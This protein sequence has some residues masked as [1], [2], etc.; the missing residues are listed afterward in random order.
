MTAKVS[1]G[2]VGSTK[3]ANRP[4][5]KLGD[6]IASADHDKDAVAYVSRKGVD[7]CF[8][9][10]PGPKYQRE[11]GARIGYDEGVH[12]DFR[13]VGVTGPYFPAKNKKHRELVARIQEAIEDGL[14]IVEDIGLE[15]LTPEAPRPPFAK[16]DSTSASA[17]KVALSVLFGD[18]H[19]G[20]VAVVKQAGIYEKANGNREEVLAVL[21]GLLAT[22]A[23]ESDAFDVEVTVS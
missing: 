13:G 8:I 19:D 6:L 17:I 23:A 16:W 11:T 15:I 7:G 14:P 22:E 21:Q 18:D 20:N 3:K 2:A 10:P 5:P 9:I 1:K 4:A 12:L